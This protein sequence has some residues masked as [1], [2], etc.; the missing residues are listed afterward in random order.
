MRNPLH[1]PQPGDVIE[2]RPGWTRTVTARYPQTVIFDGVRE[3]G[4][5]PNCELS[6][7][8]WRDT[9]PASAKVLHADQ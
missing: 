2:M 7:A 1:D 5:F 8:G 6:L 9:I 4:E 3:I